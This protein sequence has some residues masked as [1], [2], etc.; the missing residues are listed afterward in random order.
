MQVRQKW[1]QKQGICLLPGPL[2]GEISTQDLWELPLQLILNFCSQRCSLL[3]IAFSVV[4]PHITGICSCRIPFPKYPLPQEQLVKSLFFQ[5]PAQMLTVWFFPSVTLRDISAV[6]LYCTQ[7]WSIFL[8]SSFKLKIL[9][10]TDTWTL[11]LEN[12]L[13]HKTKVLF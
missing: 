10:S 9:H 12:T 1:K 3:F 11:C 13:V 5:N 4:L 7:F 6:F 8:F 2:S